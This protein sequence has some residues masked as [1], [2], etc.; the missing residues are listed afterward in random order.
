MPVENI[1]FLL[2]VF[3]TLVCITDEGMLKVD[4]FSGLIYSR[5]THFTWGTIRSNLA[6]FS[7][8]VQLSFIRQLLELSKRLF[9]YVH[10]TQGV[11]E[12]LNTFRAIKHICSHPELFLWN[13]NPPCFLFSFIFS[14]PLSTATFKDDP[15]TLT[16]IRL[17]HK[18]YKM[19]AFQW[20]SSS[21]L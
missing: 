21:S 15:R 16:I 5:L 9:I 1:F 6:S 18:N 3:N 11:K 20:N 8:S 13:L 19:S 4:E 17:K 12:L 14:L 2:L 10:Q 7:I